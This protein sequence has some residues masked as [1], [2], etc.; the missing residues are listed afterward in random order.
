MK[1][2][3]LAA[4]KAYDTIILH[5]HVR[6]DPDAYGSQMGLA[7]IIQAS[8]PEKQVFSVGND[9]ASL[10]FLGKVDEIADELYQD[11]LV[12]VCDTANTA[13]ISDRRYTAGKML[14]KID[15]HPNDEPYGDLVWVD[16]SASSCSEMIVS[17]YET[18]Q[19]ELTLHEEAAR[20][21]YAGIVGDTGRFMYPSTTSET[22]RLTAKL[23]HFPFDRPALYRHLYEQSLPMTRLAGYILEHFQ[24]E[25]GGAATVF[26][27]E[28]LLTRFEVDPREASGLVNVIDSAVG[29]KAW[30]MFIQEGDVIRA[31]LRSKG[32]VINELAKEYGG[33]GH[34]LASGATIHT[35]EEMAEMKRKLIAI[36]LETV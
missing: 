22:F 18:F 33:G 28:E 29:L 12:I 25:E 34:P 10:R 30:I 13:R 7:T 2:A 15:H 24:M 36:C 8:F 21:L 19:E 35:L 14:I 31:R 16:T 5:R 11:A 3:I 32:P 9:E 26:L 6:P 27:P 1:E 23:V 17:F 4:I 20:L